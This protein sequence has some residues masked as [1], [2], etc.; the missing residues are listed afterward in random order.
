MK[1]YFQSILLLLFLVGSFIK[2]SGQNLIWTALANPDS[3]QVNAVSF[4]SGDQQVLS[5]TNCHP[6]HIRLWNATN[7]NLFWDYE[8][9]NNLMC[10]MGAGISNDS[11]Y[12]LAVEEMGNI[13]V[14]DHSQASPDSINLIS[15]GTTYAFSMDI[16]NHSQKVLVG[17][18][19]GQLQVYRIADGLQVFSVSAHSSWVTAVKYSEN[20]SRIASGGND[21]K[22]KIWDSSGNL[23][24]TLNGH[25]DDITSLRF[26]ESG[27]TLW[28]ASKDNTLRM[29]NLLNGTLIQTLN[30]SNA[31]IHGM[32]YHPT[33]KCLVT[34]S[35]DQWIRLIHP[36]TLAR[37]DSFQQAHQTVPMCVAFSQSGSFLVTG[38]MNGLVTNYTLANVSSLQLFDEISLVV[39]CVPNP[40]YGQF[41]IVGSAD[42]TK[43]TLLDIQGRVVE[44]N[45]FPK[46]GQLNLSHLHQGVYSI[47]LNDKHGNHFSTK[48]FIQ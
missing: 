24:Y 15:M 13:L 5:A 19:G 14:F 8:V 21:N 4:S 18:S 37:I 46:D 22:I 40:S 38:T 28:S 29:W 3:L 30:V 6:A 43:Y 47:R 1:Y 42:F 23:I 27:D 11:K 17:G 20:Y 2:M 31:D 44:Q 41:Q 7:G 35:Q 25:S 39:R 36:E 48:I 34:V 10:M 16:S 32:D 45:V 33:K 12:L 26:S 9:P